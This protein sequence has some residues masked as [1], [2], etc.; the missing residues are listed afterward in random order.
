MGQQTS[1]VR[2]GVPASQNHVLITISPT[3]CGLPPR[4]AFF[5]P[6]LS[7][8]PRPST[9]PVTNR[10]NGELQHQPMSSDVVPWS[11]PFDVFVAAAVRS[12]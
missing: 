2:W 8:A 9:G 12:V 6:S 11:G 5:S 3:S 4:Q 1:L 10:H 7:R